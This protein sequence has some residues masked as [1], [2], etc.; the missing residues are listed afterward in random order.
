VTEHVRLFS[1]G[2][3]QL[4]Q[5]QCE[6]FGRQL[7]GNAGALLG[8]KQTLLEIT[9]P[10]VLKISGE[11]F[12]PIVVTSLDPTDTVAGT[13]FWITPEELAAADNYEVSDYQRVEACLASGGRAWVYVKA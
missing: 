8:F 2:T 1:Y 5:V 7:E 6:T 13:V 11:R 4:E 10:E 3:L 9:D 12:H